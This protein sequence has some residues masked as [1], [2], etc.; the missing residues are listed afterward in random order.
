MKRTMKITL[1]LFLA[2][3]AAIMISWLWYGNNTFGVTKYSL[4]LGVESPITIVQIS[5]LHGTEYGEENETLLT[6]V[7]EQS[8][9]LI[10]ITGDLI[11][12]TGE[13][14]E[15]MFS[16][17]QK[18]SA[19][20][21]VYYILGNH[22]TES[23]Y[24]SEILYGIE[25]AGA[26]VLQNEL[27]SLEVKG[28]TINILGLQEWP[29]ALPDYIYA[30]EH[31]TADSFYH[32]LFSRLEQT[33]GIRILLSHHPEYFSY[34]EEMRYDIYDFDLQLSGHAHGGQFRLPIV[35]A[36]YAPDQGWFPE[37][38]EGIYGKGP[39][40]I[41]SRGLGNHGWIPRIH[42]R[43]ELVSITIY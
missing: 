40:L 12:R 20:Y 17:I 11:T 35:G 6:A 43:P 37:Y 15:E 8:P 26:V 13:N 25:T 42:N 18:L 3:L 2:I 21:P 34:Y 30:L 39:Y 24:L 5:D 41:V 4:S 19:E 1:I 10:A 27:T 33:D 14:R 29:A 38:T 22:E 28:Q 31:R 9:D 16:L 23:E 36:C 32:S 7:R